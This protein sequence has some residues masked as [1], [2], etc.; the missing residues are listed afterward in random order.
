MAGL[1]PAIHTL[2]RVRFQNAG[3]RDKRGH[4]GRRH[5]GA[6]RPSRIRYW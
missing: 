2:I 1:D 4:D 6:V 3:T 5:G